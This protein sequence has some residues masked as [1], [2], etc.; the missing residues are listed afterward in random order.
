MSDDALLDLENQLC[1]ALD[2]AARQVMKA[3]RPALSALG[4]T[5]TQYIVLLVLWE[6]AARNESRPTV[7]ALGD[8]L[9]LDSGTLTP[10]LKRM[11]ANGLVTRVRSVSDEREVFIRLTPAGLALK[12]RASCAPRS[13][14]EHSPLRLDEIIELREQLKKLRGLF[15]T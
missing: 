8:R 11:A 3:Y 15:D 10:V 7:K 2:V 1:F 12:K 9:V 13:L 6:W 5:H 4:L 14:I